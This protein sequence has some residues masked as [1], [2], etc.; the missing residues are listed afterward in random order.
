[1]GVIYKITSPTGKLYVGQTR[2]LKRR[3]SDY[4]FKIK[5]YDTILFNSIKKYGW[6]AHIMEI[7]EDNVPDQELSERERIWIKKL[8]TYRYENQTGMNMT[9]GG[10][11][12]S[13]SWMHDVER[14]NKQSERLKGSGNPFFGKTHSD[15]FKTKHSIR[16]SDYNK[17]I[18][19]TVPEWG[20]EKSRLNKIR[21]IICYNS[22][23]DFFREFE[24]LMQIERD[25]KINHSCVYDVCNGKRSHAARYLFRYK[26]DGYPLKI[27]PGELKPQGVKKAVICEYKNKVMEFESPEA[28]SE[29]L[30]IP[31]TTIRRAAAYNNGKAIRT[32][33]IFKYKTQ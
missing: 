21:A 17:E 26:K 23:G 14:R 32:G 1:M 29:K 19:R 2:N 10:E 18:G 28:A 15:E 27:E 9:I 31:K 16:M 33:H 20:T 25:L 7:L 13:G 11:G 6:E 5:R 30:G 4:R 3:I 22:D 24:S 8:N 12:H